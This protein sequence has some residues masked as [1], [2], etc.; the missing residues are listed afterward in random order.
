MGETAGGAVDVDSQSGVRHSGT[1]V[2]AVEV[3][4]LQPQWA[5]QQVA[6]LQPQQVAQ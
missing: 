4:Q 5:P 1:A 6:Q 3:A 2:D